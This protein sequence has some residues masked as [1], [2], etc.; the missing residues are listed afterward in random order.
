MFSDKIKPEK[1]SNPKKSY[2]SPIAQTI[3]ISQLPNSYKISQK[4]SKC[5]VKK[6]S[7]KFIITVCCIYWLFHVVSKAFSISCKH[8]LQMDYQVVL[9]QTIHPLL[10]VH[11]NPKHDQ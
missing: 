3:I 11:E 5:I 9:G 8:P 7:I 4:K 2:I 1:S 10:V 6:R